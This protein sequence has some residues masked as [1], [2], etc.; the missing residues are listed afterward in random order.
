MSVKKI[1]ELQKQIKMLKDKMVLHYW[2]CNIN[3]VMRHRIPA[4]LVFVE[5]NGVYNHYFQGS[6]LMSY[7]DCL[8]EYFSVDILWYEVDFDNTLV[9]SPIEKKHFQEFYKNVVQ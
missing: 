6:N 3:E 2:G 5:Y 9:V 7:L 4:N 1:Y 8:C